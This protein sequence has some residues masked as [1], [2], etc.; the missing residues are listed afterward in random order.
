[1]GIEVGWYWDWEMGSRDLLEHRLREG[2]ERAEVH[3]YVSH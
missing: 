3:G 2:I 1:V